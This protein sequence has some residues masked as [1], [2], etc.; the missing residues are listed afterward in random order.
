MHQ[1]ADGETSGP[2][3]EEGGEHFSN[4]LYVSPTICPKKYVQ[5]QQMTESL[6]A[7]KKESRSPGWAD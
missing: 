1:Q 4:S 7:R 3:P 2:H 6:Y 5:L